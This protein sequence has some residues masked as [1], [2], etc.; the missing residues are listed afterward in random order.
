MTTEILGLVAAIGVFAGSLIQ[1]FQAAG[2]IGLN[3][4]LNSRRSM[5]P[6]YLTACAVDIV[7]LHRIN[8]YVESRRGTDRI[9]RLEEKV[10]QEAF[11][12]PA[13]GWTV[14]LG[15]VTGLLKPAG[16]LKVD[17]EASSRIFWA[18][19]LILVGATAGIAAALMALVK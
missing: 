11:S 18:W 12:D 3:L 19:S 9:D 4:I 7:T 5:V 15:Y 6:I 10:A 1:A 2:Q 14:L 8:K 16:P 17:L 13:D